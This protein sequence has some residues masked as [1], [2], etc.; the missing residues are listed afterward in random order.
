MFEELCNFGN[1]GGVWG[2][3]SSVGE[4]H[5]THL[6]MLTRGKFR[7]EPLRTTHSNTECMLYELLFASFL[8]THEIIRLREDC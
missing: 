7:R 2:R 5:H 8:I 3:V 4:T 6:P 1:F